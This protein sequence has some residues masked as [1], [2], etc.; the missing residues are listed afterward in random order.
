MNNVDPVEFYGKLYDEVDE[1]RSKLIK[2][3]RK[4]VPPALK[5]R[6]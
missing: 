5:L 4:N 6:T 3:L 1:I 2:Q